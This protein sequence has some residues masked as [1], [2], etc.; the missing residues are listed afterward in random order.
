MKSKR[1]QRSKRTKRSK[2]R[3]N[4]ELSLGLKAIRL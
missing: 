2:R 4:P 1:N 3:R